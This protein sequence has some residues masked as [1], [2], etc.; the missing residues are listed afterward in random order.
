MNS[1]KTVFFQME[2][3][4]DVQLILKRH[5]KR[6]VAS[7]EQG[8]DVGQYV[9]DR[10]HEVGVGLVLFLGSSGHPRVGHEQILRNI[11]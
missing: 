8:G 4:Q 1:Q 2:I 7:R 6:P 11:S 5:L 9:V 10:F 3:H